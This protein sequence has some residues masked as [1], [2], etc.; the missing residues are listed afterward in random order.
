MRNRTTEPDLH[1]KVVL[2]TGAT[3]GLGGVLARRLA[4]RGATLVLTGRKADKLEK[5]AGEL[6]PRAVAVHVVS[7]DLS[8]PAG[9]EALVAKVDNE[10]GA[11]DILVSNAGV[12]YYGSYARHDVSE[13]EET[14]TTNLLSPMILVHA[15][16]P[17]MLDRGTGH[18][19]L[20]SSISGKAPNPYG[21]AYAASKAGLVG[22]SSSLRTELTGTGVSCSVICPAFVTDVEDGMFIRIQREGLRTPGMV[23]VAPA[24]RCADAVMRVLKTGEPE[25]IVSDK[26]LRPML[27]AAI[28][29]P[30][31]SDRVLAEAGVPEFFKQLSARRGRL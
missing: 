31:L 5:L 8:S 7:A 9:V 20:T 18:I 22:L 25:I 29:W 15:V 4:D 26:P 30:S 16:L 21:A 14:I 1:G 27:A 10:V 13:L 6:T 28:L 12:E 24:A 2:L 17:G 3:G 19:V 23:G 11:L